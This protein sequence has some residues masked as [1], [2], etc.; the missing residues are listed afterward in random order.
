MLLAILALPLLADAF[1]P[2]HFG[3]EWQDRILSLGLQENNASDTGCAVAVRDREPEI[4]LNRVLTS[5]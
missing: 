5:S 3:F 2:D 4:H 1:L